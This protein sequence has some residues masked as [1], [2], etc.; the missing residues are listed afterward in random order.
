MS[1]P[2]RRLSLREFV[3][4]IA[5]DVLIGFLQATGFLK[6]KSFKG[7]YWARKESTGEW[8]LRVPY[9]SRKPF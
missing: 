8:E 7:A 3:K 2:S 9:K 1:K 6:L 5:H 4:P